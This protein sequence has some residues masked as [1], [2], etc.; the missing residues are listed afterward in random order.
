MKKALTIAGSDSSG[1]AGIQA[2]IK[3]FSAL[4]FYCS[5]VITILTAQNTETVS[6]IFITPSKFFRNQ[7]SFTINDIKPDII[8]IGVLY[9]NSIIDVVH[10]SL[11][12]SKIPIV[13][14]PVLFSGTGIK[15]LKDSAYDNF[16][17]KN[18]SNFF[19]NHS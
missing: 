17:K 8:K 3:T 11:F 12:Q 18:N 9:D 5:T 1:G 2:D 10:D 13:L 7:L 19:N 16:K 15:L 4:G 6:D 14:D